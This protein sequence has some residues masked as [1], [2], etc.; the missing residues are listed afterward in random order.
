MDKLECLKNDEIGQSAAKP[1]I[2][3]GSTTIPKGSRRNPK[4]VVYHK[5]RNVIYSITNLVNHKRYIGSAAFFDKRMGTHVS[6]LNSKT[7]WNIHL[8]QAWNKYGKDNFKLEVIEMVDSQT[9]L[10]ER[11]QYYIDLF[12]S[13]DR[14][15]GYNISCVAS[16]RLG[17]KMSKEAKEKISNFFKGVKF[18]NERIAKLKANR[19]KAQGVKVDVYNKNKTFYKTFDSL[20]EAARHCNISIGAIRKQCNNPW[21]NKPRNYVFRYKDMV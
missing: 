4:Q 5:V 16:S 9:S 3:E 20:S 8:Q 13:C 7:H 6:K 10:I 12:Q 1:Q 18:S 14:K 11:E 17:T 21:P 2:E 15:N 19:T